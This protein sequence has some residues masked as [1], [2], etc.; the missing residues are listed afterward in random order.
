MPVASD[1]VVITG[2]APSSG[3]DPGGERVGP[4][5]VPAGQRHGE[6]AGLVDADH[7][8][9]GV[10]VGQ[11]RRDQPHGRPGGQEEHR[12]VQP[13]PE[14]GQLGQLGGRTAPSAAATSAAARRP[15]AVT[16]N[17]AIT[18]APPRGT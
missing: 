8:G 17:R 11:Q 5:A 4:A 18:V 12:P 10:L 3:G 7:A 16:A 2:R 14:R 6:P 9:V 1:A 15:A 13:R